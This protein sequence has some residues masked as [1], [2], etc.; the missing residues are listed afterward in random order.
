MSPVPAFHLC[1]NR[2]H[3]ERRP[4]SLLRTA[5]PST[6]S[7]SQG[8]AS[9]RSAPLDHGSSDHRPGPSRPTTNGRQT[10]TTTPAAQ[11]LRLQATERQF[12]RSDELVDALSVLAPRSEFIGRFSIVAD[13]AV[14]NIMRARM[15]ADHL[16]A[17]ALPISY[18][19]SSF[20]F[21]PTTQADFYLPF[22]LGEQGKRSAAS[23]RS[24]QEFVRAPHSLHLPGSVYWSIHRHCRRRHVASLWCTWPTHWCN[25]LASEKSD[26]ESPA[27]RACTIPH[28]CYA[29][30]IPCIAL[31][32]CSRSS[33]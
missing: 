6:S 9:G 10:R 32:S 26:S 28:A 15:F 33:W 19:T 12:Q 14:S 13:P 23:V 4:S 1:Q 17:K 5:D 8:P 2:T 11:P 22:R 18:A 29:Y 31:D 7:H 20:F 16:R 30:S 24:E 3:R 21:F 27:L 25:P